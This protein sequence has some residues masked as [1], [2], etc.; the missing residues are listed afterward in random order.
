M[1]KIHRYLTL[2][3][4]MLMTLALCV[5]SAFA[6]TV[7]NATIDTTRKG[8][9]D[10]YK[11]D[12]TSAAADGVWDEDSY[13]STG[14]FDQAI[15]DTL[16]D[17]YAIQG[18]EFTYLRVADISTYSK[19]E[20]G[21]QKIAVQYGFTKNAASQAILGA[22]GLNYSDAYSTVGNI[23]YFESDVLDNALTAA[24]TANATNAKN[25]L[26]TAIKANGGVAM[27]ETDSHGHTAASNLPLG[28]YLIVETR[29]PENV[30]ST[31]NPCLISLPM[32]TIDGLNWNYAVT[33]YPK[34]QT[35][36]PTLEKTVREA[37]ADTGK[38]NASQVITDGFAHTATGSDGDKVE[39]QIISKLPTITSQ[40]SFLTMYDYVDT[41]S[42]GIQYDKNDVQIEFFRNAACTDK[43]TT[44]A[45][46]SAQ[47]QIAYG[48]GVNTMTISMTA[49]G[50]SEINTATSVYNAASLNR[51][52]SDC[53]M[54]I[55][56]G[57]HIKSDASVVYGD[58][59]NPNEVVLTWK[60]TNT[61]YFDTLRDDCHVYTYGIDLLKQFSDDNGNYSNVKFK[62]YNDTDNYYVKAQ[63]TDGVYYVT[64]H[65]AAEADATV[66]VP[67]ADGHI[68]VKGL[69]DD[70][71]TITEIATDAGYVL[72]KDNIKVV[73]STAAGA[74]CPVCGKPL[75]TAS[76]KVNNDAV[77]MSGNHAIVPLTVMNNR[78]YT[79]PKTGSYGTWMFTVG[80]VLLIGAAGAVFFLNR[81][82]SEE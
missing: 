61:T 38:N 50:L 27:T 42:G 19:Q 18:V 77:T 21:Q 73:I 35:G 7:A 72:L 46:G 49:A 34:N 51:G 57:C 30:T 29:V 59:G 8:S 53:Y 58:D 12:M 79:L 78:G 33:A 81:K 48:N 65:K 62:V 39:Y 2:A 64:D 10:L 17:C 43:I 44:W 16:N 4:A 60:R 52:Y 37:K 28:L 36:N 74:N 40:A 3:L 45:P 26:E 67:Q 69:E 14:Q 15:L 41:L 55:T 23:C 31:C 80:G 24:L 56:Y 76:A 22:M 11:Y 6:A 70:A 20:S 66:F 32:T 9:L 82:K 54:R 13:V 47:F 68:I 71:Y 75:L 5:T 25:A 1:K 63:L